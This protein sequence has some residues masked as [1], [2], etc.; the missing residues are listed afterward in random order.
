MSVTLLFIS[1]IVVYAIISWKFFPEYKIITIIAASFC[2]LLYGYLLEYQLYA[3]YM[4]L[5]S[6]VYGIL[7]YFIFRKKK[8]KLYDGFLKLYYI[9]PFFVSMQELIKIVNKI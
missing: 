7:L 8:F 9:I 3:L 4:P 2:W 1:I 6:I 5:F